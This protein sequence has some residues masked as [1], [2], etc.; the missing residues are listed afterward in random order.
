MSVDPTSKTAL[1]LIKGSLRIIGQYAPGETLT[2][3]DANDALDV[4]NGLFDVLSNESLAVFNNN[5]NIV[6]LTAGK[7]VYTI[8]SGGDIN[9]QRPL[10][11][12][13]AY[14]RM[15]TA[16]SGVDF[17][18]DIKDTAAYTSIGMKMQPGPW[19]KVLYYNTGF[20]LAQLFLWPVPQR[21]I[22]FHFWTDMLL[23]SVSLT[24]QLSL[25]Q[26]YYLYLQFALAEA[27]APQYGVAVS[28]DVLRLTRRYLKSIKSN[29][30]TPDRLVA[31][32]GAISMTG[33][34]DAGFY[35]TGGF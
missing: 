11:I 19:P 35:L 27:L 31:I 13:Q 10:R 12:T 28:A 34:A 16:G 8:G 24:T 1:D 3:D 17:Q 6:T 22:E 14:S 29:N 2:A 4:L 30:S 5:E 23:Q 26:G 20:P 33:S 32:D 7:Q 9:I 15:T 18:C 21:A 25:P